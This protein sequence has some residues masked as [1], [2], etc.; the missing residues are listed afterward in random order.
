MESFL[1]VSCH[2]LHVW[3]KV[4]CED[5]IVWDVELCILV[6]VPVVLEELIASICR[7]SSSNLKVKAA[8]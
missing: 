8:C 5:T 3:H 1:F 2:W 7:F 6:D 4:I